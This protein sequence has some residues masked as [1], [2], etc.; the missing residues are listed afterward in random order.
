MSAV[1]YNEAAFDAAWIRGVQLAGPKFFAAS[2]D[3]AESTSKWNF[4]PDF[5]RI[6]DALG[7][8]STGEAVLLAAMYS[9]YNSDDGAA[10][11]AS[12]GVGSPGAVAAALDERRR[13]VIADLTIAY[14]GW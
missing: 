12:L 6:N 7:V 8:L 5:D 10:M 14:A 1:F 4:C 9:F 11:L 2:R 3:A 13:R